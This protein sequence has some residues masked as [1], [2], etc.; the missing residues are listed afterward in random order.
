[1]VVVDELDD[2]VVE[3]LVVGHVRVRRMNAHHLGQHFWNRPAV[4]GDLVEDLAGAHL[5]A[6]EHAFFEPLV[7]AGDCGGG[8]HGRTSRRAVIEVAPC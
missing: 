6:G 1:V 3:T 5:V 8:G 4:L 2:A 7:A